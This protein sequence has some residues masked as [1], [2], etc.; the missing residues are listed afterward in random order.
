MTRNCLSYC[1]PNVCAIKECGI[2]R[3]CSRHGHWEIQI[4]I[5]R[6][7]RRYGRP[8]N[9]REDNIKI[10]VASYTYTVE[11]GRMLPRNAGTVKPACNGTA[12]DR[13]ISVTGRF[14]SIRVFEM[15]I[16]GVPDPFDCKSASLKI[17]ALLGYYAASCGLIGPLTRE[18]GTDALSRNVGNYHTGSWPV[19]MGPMRCPETSVIT[20]RALDPWRWDRCVVPKCR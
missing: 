10:N 15:W 8:G 17:C 2:V 1:S 18:D 13:N 20:T 4:L 3:T 7:G 11:G 19:K 9:T 16:V 5:R 14:L 6:L 12:G